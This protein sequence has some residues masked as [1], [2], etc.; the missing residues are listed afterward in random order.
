M[1]VN[2]HWLHVH[3]INAVL[4]QSNSTSIVVGGMPSGS[5]NVALYC[6]HPD[7]M[8]VDPATATMPRDTHVEVRVT[9]RPLALG[10]L[11]MLIHIVEQ[12][13]GA[14]LDALL[15]HTHT[16]APHISRMFEVDLP[17]GTIIQKKVWP[18]PFSCCLGWPG[19]SG[20]CCGWHCVGL[21]ACLLCKRTPTASKWQR[22]MRAEACSAHLC[23]AVPWSMRRVLVARRLC[24]VQSQLCLYD[25]CSDRGKIVGNHGCAEE[26]MIQSGQVCVTTETRPS[27][28]WSVMIR[29]TRAGGLP[30]Y[31]PRA[32][33]VCATIQQPCAGSVCHA[34]GGRAR[35]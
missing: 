24:P 2:V 32:A 15:M 11:N 35:P 31:V 16:R 30:K 4:G 28:C 5:K 21:E 19:S 17:V 1:Q 29:C 33:H 22:S 26:Q 7:E 18:P 8:S 10:S 3:D 13:T 12:G 23:T 6:S 20:W 27:V 14:F 9:F 34:G 25:G